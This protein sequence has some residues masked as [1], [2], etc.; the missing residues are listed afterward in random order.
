MDYCARTS[1]CVALN[2]EMTEDFGSYLGGLCGEV[3]K[4]KGE[5]IFSVGT[6]FNDQ[7]IMEGWGVDHHVKLILPSLP[8]L[9]RKG[10]SI[11]V[12]NGART[13]FWVHNW[14]MNDPLRTHTIS[15]IPT[16]IEGDTIEEMWEGSKTSG[17]SIKYALKFIRNDDV[18]LADP[19]WELVWKT[20]A[21]QRLRPEVK[22]VKIGLEMAWDLGTTKLEVQM[23]NEACIVAL[24][25]PLYQGGECFLLFNQCRHL[26]NSS[27]WEVL[28]RHCYREGNKV[29]DK[30][31]NVGDF[32][33]E[34][35]VFYNAPSAD[36]VSLL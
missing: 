29:V 22:A 2:M 31:A 20:P 36:I 11:A 33:L 25:D 24:N 10:T 12:G 30:L 23:D 19:Q 35:L 16:E 18:S 14:P 5:F 32:Q 34:T 13:L 6:H 9:I 28:F 27:E 3:T 21:Q 17:F 7:E 15:S 26:I 4:I 1:I 8:S